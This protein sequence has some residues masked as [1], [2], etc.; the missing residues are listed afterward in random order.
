[1]GRASIVM[2]SLVALIL[3]NLTPAVALDVENCAAALVKTEIDT[4]SVKTLDIRRSSAVDESAWHRAHDK[5][6]A[7]G[8][9]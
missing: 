4:G 3:W 1:M 7:E 6:G 9:L 5:Y 8:M 2:A